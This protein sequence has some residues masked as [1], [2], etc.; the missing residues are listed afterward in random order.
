MRKIGPNRLE[1]LKAFFPMISHQAHFFARKGPKAWYSFLPL[2]SQFHDKAKEY[3][4]LAKKGEKM[5]L[6]YQKP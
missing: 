5:F 4:K 3:T 1:L 6:A 2:F